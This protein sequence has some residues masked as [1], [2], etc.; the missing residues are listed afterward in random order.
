MSV[1]ENSLIADQ[2]IRT[3]QPNL[4]GNSVQR[5]LRNKKNSCK[6]PF[7]R[8]SYWIEMICLKAKYFFFLKVKR[9]LTGNNGQH[10]AYIWYIQRKNLSRL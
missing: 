10:T 2:T 3:V 9:K 5:V 1:G 6:L 7:I 8:N 4:L